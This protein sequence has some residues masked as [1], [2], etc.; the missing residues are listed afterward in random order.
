[1]L[2]VT[3]LGALVAGLLSFVSPC[4]LPMVPFYLG[5]LAGTGVQNLAEDDAVPTAVRR[6]AVLASALFALGVIT[7]FVALGAS[8]SFFGQ[9]VRD[10]FDI[11]K[12]AAAAIIF[13]MSDIESPWLLPLL[14]P[15]LATVGDMI[16]ARTLG[17]AA[18][19]GE[20]ADF[21]MNAFFKY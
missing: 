14:E 20:A 19:L 17:E 7:I 13:A 3:F 9:M 2:N 5:Y 16:P 4:I 6:R 10:Y 12:W 1:M 21:L 15:G 18:A 11:L 8:A